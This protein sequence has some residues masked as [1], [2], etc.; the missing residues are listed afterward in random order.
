VA[1]SLGDVTRRLRE[2]VVALDRRAPRTDRAAEVAIAH[3]AA[4]LREKAM[5]RLAEL[6]DQTLP[7]PDDRPGR[8][9]PAG[10]R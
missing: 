7:T 9:R 4:V 8:V 1:V 2:L 3:D 6:A 10:R 5:S